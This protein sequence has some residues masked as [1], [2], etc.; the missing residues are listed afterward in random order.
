MIKKLLYFLAFDFCLFIVFVGCTDYT[1]PDE[2]AA[3]EKAKIEIQD[4][5]IAQEQRIADEAAAR[6]ALEDSLMSLVD[7]LGI[8]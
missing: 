6:Q 7:S 8:Q 2:K 5:R 4:E 3:A 1:S